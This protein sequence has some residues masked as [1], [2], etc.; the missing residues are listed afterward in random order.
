MELLIIVFCF[1]L[2]SCLSEGF[3]SGSAYKNSG[4]TLPEKEWNRLTG[5]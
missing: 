3:P 5:H 2:V 4:S 1:W